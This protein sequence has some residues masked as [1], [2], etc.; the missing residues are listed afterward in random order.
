MPTCRSL[1]P[2]DRPRDNLHSDSANTSGRCI[3]PVQLGLDSQRRGCRCAEFAHANFDLLSS[4]LGEPSTIR[5]SLSG[6]L[7]AIIWLSLRP[8]WSWCSLDSAVKRSHYMQT[9]SD[10]HTSSLPVPTFSD[11]ICPT[12]PSLCPATWSIIGA[13][14][15]VVS[16]GSC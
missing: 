2:S 1:H 5:F 10:G 13:S 16:V 4:M 9:L 12:T 15:H 8:S 6:P 14:H 7:L 11:H 3:C